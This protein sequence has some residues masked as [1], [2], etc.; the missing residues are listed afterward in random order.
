M[1]KVVRYK[2]EKGDS[3][4]F[5]GNVL[6]TVQHLKICAACLW[7]KMAGII[8]LYQDDQPG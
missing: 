6:R 8:Y 7:G 4:R 2:R 3:L 5:Y 1:E